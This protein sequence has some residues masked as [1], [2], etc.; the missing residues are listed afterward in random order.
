MTAGAVDAARSTAA[1]DRKLLWVDD[2]DG[3]AGAQP[4]PAFWT[5]ELGDGTEQGIPGWGN[6]ELQR[7]TADRPNS[8]LDGRGNLA[9]T[10][11]RDESG[12]G[13]YTSA[14]LITRGAV[15]VRYGRLE[16]RVRVPRGAGLWPAFWA[17]GADIGE[18]GWPACGE[19]DV[20]EHV[21]RQP[22][23]VYGAI[24]GPGYSGDAGLART[25]HLTTDV[26]EDFHVFAVE[27]APAELVWSVDRLDYHRAT[28]ADVAP[29]AWAF[30][31][32]FYLLLNLAVGGGLGGEVADETAFPAQMLVDYVRVYAA[33]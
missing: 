24:H 16:A 31:H 5:H 23:R 1:R 4:D 15:E 21:G 27:W 11:R 12:R 19:I 32:P 29:R 17:L 30:G 7:Y 14:R 3:P 28:P 9:V 25:H 20:M 10:A 8:A 2:F 33:S 22:R 13:A 26:A 6:G 18:A